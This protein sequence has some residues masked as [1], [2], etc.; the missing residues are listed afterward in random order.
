MSEKVS[1]SVS[2]MARSS[3]YFM[4]KAAWSNL[5]V[6]ACVKHCVLAC[7]CVQRVQSVYVSLQWTAISLAAGNP[8]NV[9][10]LVPSNVTVCMSVSKGYACVFEQQQQP[11]AQCQL[12]SP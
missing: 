8:G 11:P 1:A 10:P 4:H 6:C 3:D 12:D 9:P 7:M 5:P 2:P